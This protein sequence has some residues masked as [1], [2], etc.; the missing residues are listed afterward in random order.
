MGAPSETFPPYNAVAVA[1]VGGGER[2]SERARA[3][4]RVP[5]LNV[6]AKYFKFTRRDKFA[7]FNLFA[8]VPDYR[9]N[10]HRSPGSGVNTSRTIHA[11]GA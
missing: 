4:A 3:F 10:G 6:S 1:V 9:L 11:K 8:S 5:P 7:N 2:A